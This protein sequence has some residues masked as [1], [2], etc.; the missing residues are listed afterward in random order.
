MK[1]KVDITKPRYSEQ[2]LLVPWPFFISRF[3]FNLP[4]LKCQFI[5]LSAS[6]TES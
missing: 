4:L 1:T 3:H 2:I 6:F 5:L